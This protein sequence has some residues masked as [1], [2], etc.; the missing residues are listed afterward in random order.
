MLSPEYTGQTAHCIKK[1]KMFLFN[2][3]GHI[4]WKLWHLR[5]SNGQ[6]YLDKKLLIFLLFV[7]FSWITLIFFSIGKLSSGYIFI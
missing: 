7:Y 2:L 4:I 3:L 1:K 6:A 5:E